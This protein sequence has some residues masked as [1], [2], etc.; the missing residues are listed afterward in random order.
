MC[1]T[2]LPSKAPTATYRTY[3]GTLQTSPTLVTSL[4]LTYRPH[5]RPL[6]QYKRY[7]F[8]QSGYSES[9]GYCFSFSSDNSFS[10]IL[11]ICSLEYLKV[12]KLEHYI[13]LFFSE[14]GKIPFTEGTCATR[15]LPKFSKTFLFTQQF[16]FS[17][18]QLHQG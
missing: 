16:L 15:A 10:I 8:T 13:S 11:Q 7:T 18:R 3:Q 14:L 4:L 12:L 6:G 9:Q 17:H 5:S 2:R 1:V